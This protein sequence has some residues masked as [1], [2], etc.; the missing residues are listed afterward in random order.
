MQVNEI[1]I[2]LQALWDFFLICLATGVC[3]YWITFLVFVWND[4]PLNHADK[5]LFTQLILKCRKIR[6]QR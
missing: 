3:A 4:E 6:R 1:F 2:V 5:S